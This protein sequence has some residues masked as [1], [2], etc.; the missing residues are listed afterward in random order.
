MDQLWII[1]SGKLIY[2]VNQTFIF[3]IF[4]RPLRAGKIDQNDFSC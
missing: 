3:P 2:L 4:A 1:Y